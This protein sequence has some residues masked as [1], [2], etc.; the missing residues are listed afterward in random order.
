VT[1]TA[2][3]VCGSRTYADR[4]KVTEKLR[5]LAG[6]GPVVIIHGDATG[7]DSLAAQVALSYNYTVVPMPYISALG[8]AGG[9]RRNQHMSVVLTALRAVGYD[10]GVIA[11]L[12][13]PFEESR[14][15]RNMVELARSCG[16]PV[17][18]VEL[19]GVS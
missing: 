16:F 13:K 11:F 1:N 12:D 8:K 4:G 6:H 10:V 19:V 14:G 7:A 5:L 17:D 9:P 15:T 3:I 18:L 2:R